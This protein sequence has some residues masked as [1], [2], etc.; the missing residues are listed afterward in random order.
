MRQN[1]V[2][3]HNQLASDGYLIYIIILFCVQSH[4]TS[5]KRL[6]K[7]TFTLIALGL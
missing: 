7:N 5:D 3:V 1:S 6:L 2:Y 4:R